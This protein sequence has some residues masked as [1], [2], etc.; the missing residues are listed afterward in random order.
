V[1]AIVCDRA[2]DYSAAAPV[3]LRDATA[4]AAESIRKGRLLGRISVTEEAEY[5]RVEEATIE[6]SLKDEVRKIADVGPERS[7]RRR[8]WGGE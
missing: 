5:L 8:I 3:K 6:S 4:R 1:A 7:A 2:A